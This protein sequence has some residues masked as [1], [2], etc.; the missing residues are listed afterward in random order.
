M[1]WCFLAGTQ[2]EQD[3][4]VT[5]F[6]DS[7]SVHQFRYTSFSKINKTLGQSIETRHRQFFWNSHLICIIHFV[8]VSFDLLIKC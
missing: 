8:H 2:F 6:T 4:D 5:I 1:T 7:V 3:Y